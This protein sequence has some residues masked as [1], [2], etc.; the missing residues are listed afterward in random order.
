MGEFC[1]EFL[2]APVGCSLALGGKFQFFSHAVEGFGEGPEIIVFIHLERHVK[3]ALG[4]AC[5]KIGKLIEGSDI[6]VPDNDHE[7][8]ACSVDDRK[9]RDELALRSPEQGFVLFCSGIK[10]DL[11]LDH[12]VF[13]VIENRH[14]FLNEIAVY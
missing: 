12:A 6:E 1:D 7:N 8:N 4:D 5:S 10:C 14:V 11:A 13:H 9:H 3:I 2:F